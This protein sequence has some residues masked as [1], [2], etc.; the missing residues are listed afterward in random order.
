M[1]PRIITALF[2]LV[3]PA[4]LVGYISAT[5]RLI[6]GARQMAR[7][8]PAVA[9]AHAGAPDPAPAFLIVPTMQTI[10]YSF[11]NKDGRMAGLDNYAW[12]LNGP[13]PSWRLSTTS[14]GWSSSLAHDRPRPRGRRPRRPRPLRVAGQ[15]DPLHADGDQR[16]LRRV[17]WKFMYWY[18]PRASPRPAPERKS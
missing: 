15:V 7:A 3:V 1:D 11:H 5:E 13:E 17:I 8:D 2:V 12:F 16:R 9:L 6:R 18:Q 4:V 14:S 10:W